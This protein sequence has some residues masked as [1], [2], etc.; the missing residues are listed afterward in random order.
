MLGDSRKQHI[1]GIVTELF[2][3]RRDIKVLDAGAGTG[4][5]GQ[6]VTIFDT[7]VFFLVKF[8]NV[9]VISIIV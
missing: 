2:K 5:I 3:E 6:M 4:N 9:L 7:L 8:I 1:C